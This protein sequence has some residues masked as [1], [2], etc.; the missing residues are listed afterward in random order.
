A[1][2]LAVDLASGEVEE[3]VKEVDGVPLRF[4]NNAA[5]A[6]D[7]TIYFSDSSRHYSIEDWKS[8]LIE[9]TLT[10]RL[11]RRTPDGTVTTLLDGLGLANGVALTADGDQV[12]VA[13]TALRRIRRLDTAGSE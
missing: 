1:G 4:T 3:L 7:G 12:W 6:E 10:G 11:F 13:E 8:D 2:L 9:H 5:V